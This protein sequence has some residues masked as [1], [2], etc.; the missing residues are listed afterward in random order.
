MKPGAFDEMEALRSLGAADLPAE[1]AEAIG[2][3]CHA[4]LAR[5][6]RPGARTARRLLGGLELA[7]AFAVGLAYLVWGLSSASQ[8]FLDSRLIADPAVTDGSAVAA[9]RSGRPTP[10]APFSGQAAG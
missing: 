7:A 2:R 10:G 1:R 5:R 9:A 3:R 4:E 8:V 6:A